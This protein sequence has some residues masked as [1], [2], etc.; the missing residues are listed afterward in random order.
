MANKFPVVPMLFVAAAFGGLL[1]VIAGARK[2]PSS[3]LTPVFA[4]HTNRFEAK[5]DAAALA[6]IAKAMADVI[7][8]DGRLENPRI[9]KAI[10]V[11]DMRAA[12]REYRMEGWSFLSRYDGLGAEL[13][14]LF[15]PVGTN[16]GELSPERRAIWVDAFRRCQSEADAAAKSL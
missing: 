4:S 9:K 7:E 10:H 2:G 6:E 11:D 8:F 14:R 1:L 3:P 12:V 16:T 15:A 13:D 5:A